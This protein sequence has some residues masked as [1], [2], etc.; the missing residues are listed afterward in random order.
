MNFDKLLLNPYFH[1]ICP[2][3]KGLCSGNGQWQIKKIK[4]NHSSGIII[5]VINKKCVTLHSDF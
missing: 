3:K 4:K 2:T 5:C 1:L